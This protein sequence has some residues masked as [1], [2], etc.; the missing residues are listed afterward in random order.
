[1]PRPSFAAPWRLGDRGAS[2][3]NLG[4]SGLAKSSAPRFVV[5]GIKKTVSVC[6]GAAVG[7]APS[8]SESWHCSQTNQ[9]HLGF[10]S[11]FFSFALERSGFDHVD[12]HFAIT[13]LRDNVT[14]TKEKF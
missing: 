3:G 6:G 12:S 9:A 13:M 4:P 11:F 8:H 14:T 10:S 2:R 1:M 7:R 5:V